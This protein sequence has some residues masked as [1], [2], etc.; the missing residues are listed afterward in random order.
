MWARPRRGARLASTPSAGGG[1]TVALVATRHAGVVLLGTAL[2]ACLGMRAYTCVDD[3]QCVQDGEQG[4]CEATGWCSFAD[5]DCDSERRYGKWAGMGLAGRCTTRDAAT[6]GGDTVADGDVSDEGSTSTD[7]G[8][9]TSASTG[10]DGCDTECVSPGAQLWM[11]IE[12]GPAGGSDALLDVAVDALGRSFVSGYVSV[13]G[14]G[15][16]ILVREVSP[17]GEPVWTETYDGMESASDQA[18]G[19]AIDS[20]NAV[21]LAGEIASTP[22]AAYIGRYDVDGTALWQMERPGGGF[23][24]AV[25]PLD[26]LVVVGR[27]EGDAWL[28]K[29]DGEGGLVWELTYPGPGSSTVGWDVTVDD[30]GNV[31]AIGSEDTADGQRCWLRK[32]TG[33]GSSLQWN[34]GVAGVGA[35]ANQGLGIAMAPDGDIVAVG[36]MSV[37]EDHHAWVAKYGPQGQLKWTKSHTGSDGG[38]ANA[39]H[40]AV[41]VE[42][43]IIVGGWKRQGSGDLDAWVGKYSPDGNETWSHT[44]GGDAEE[45]DRAWGV[46]VDDHGHV[47][48]VGYLHM[49]D[50]GQNLWMAK[51]AP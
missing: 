17:D 40:V 3:E 47:L 29:Y 37:D 30:D 4:F 49:L 45:D 43:N 50:G 19:I 18:W 31:I 1:R 28:A 12:D 24:V 42:G 13:E 11:I 51:Y 16:D 14:Q 41:D 34:V 36:L 9:E 2:G 15:R 6:S 48:A 21:V 32:Y 22:R 26:D 8:S 25:T 46:A 44:H 5:D 7:E 23:D 35:G 38:T 10:D 20:E 27:I 39:H 33:D